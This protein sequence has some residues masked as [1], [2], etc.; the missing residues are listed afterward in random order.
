MLYFTSVQA[1]LNS[2]RL[3]S[4]D[5]PYKPTTFECQESHSNKY[6]G[7]NKYIGN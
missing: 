5:N 6:I 3:I 1:N 2:F 4:Q 7:I